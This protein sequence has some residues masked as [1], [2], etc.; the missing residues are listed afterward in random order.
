MP[1]GSHNAADWRLQEKGSTCVS[2][3]QAQ[4]G[5]SGALDVQSLVFPVHII[6]VPVDILMLLEDI[7]A[8]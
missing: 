2:R 1:V 5:E 3:E 7:Q 8:L 4:S 6:S